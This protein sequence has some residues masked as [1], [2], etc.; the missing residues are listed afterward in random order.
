MTQEAQV[1]DRQDVATEVATPEPWLAVVAPPVDVTETKDAIQVTVDLPGV[2]EQAL[3]IDVEN[4]V[5]TLT[6]RARVDGPPNGERVLG[7]FDAVLY[8]R[9]LRL[10]DRLSAENITAQLKHGVL[11][12]SI[13]KREEKKARKIVVTPA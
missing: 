12:V 10:S 11:R 1:L 2:E 7:E 3:D 5:L 8:K 9:A 6:G 13:P 4:G